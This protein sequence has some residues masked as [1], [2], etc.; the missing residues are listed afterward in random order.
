MQQVDSRG[1]MI[2]DVH[3]LDGHCMVAAIEG[4]KFTPVRTSVLA[5]L[6]PQKNAPNITRKIETEEDTGSK[7]F[8]KAMA[9]PK[10][11]PL[12]TSFQ[13]VLGTIASESGIR[14][15]A[16][17]DCARF[18]DLGFDSLL[19]ISV[20]ARLQDAFKIELSSILF[21]T[22]ASAAELRTHF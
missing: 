6:L 11:L 8:S 2:G 21:V 3:V 14:R 4:V 7:T 19:T 20:L 12:A 15:E 9:S 22:C 17:E 18:E 10:N 1:I 16:L 5:T 13:D